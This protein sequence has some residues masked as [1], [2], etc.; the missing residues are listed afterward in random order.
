[1]QQR[2]LEFSVASASSQG[3]RQYQEDATRVWYPNGAEASD[4]RRPVVLAVLSDGMGGHVSGEVASKLVCDQSMQHFLTPP[5]EPEGKIKTVLNASNAS[6]ANA[7]RSNSKLSGMGCTL[8]AAY[9]DS[10][11]V[12]WASVG[13]SSLLLFRGDQLY[14][15]N[16]NHSLGALLDRQ[17]AASLITYEE[18]QNSPNRHSLRSA[19]TGG[20]IAISDIVYT[21]QSTL[22]GDWVIIASDG[23]DTLTA[24]EIATAIG[25]ASTGTPADLTRNLL[26]Q[27][28]RK[29]VPNQDNTSVIAVRVHAGKTAYMR[30]GQQDQASNATE[31]TPD[32]KSDTEVIT[33][34][35]HG[36]LIGQVKNKTLAPPTVVIRRVAPARSTGFRSVAAL[37]LVLVLASAFFFFYFLDT[38]E[39]LTTRNIGRQNGDGAQQAPALESDAKSD[40][41]R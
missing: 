41:K 39:M 15:L 37:F 4:A 13:D 9:L 14:R 21:P 3:A 40:E 22:P 30:V 26:D 20:P 35:I 33:S 38:V 29:A 6:L 24:D 12:R 10:E 17:A 32:R 19:L 23:L 11:G 2:R 8:V 28:G 27:V 34:M 16:E 5:G 31:A 1:M 18:A 36:T 25:N 7:I